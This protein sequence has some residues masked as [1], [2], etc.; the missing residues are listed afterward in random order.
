MLPKRSHGAAV[1]GDRPASLRCL[2]CPEYGPEAWGAL[3]A[4]ARTAGLPD[5]EIR[6]AILSAQ[7][8]GGAA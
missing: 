1:E 4:A 6:K 3:A 7:Q 5:H 2:G 8:T